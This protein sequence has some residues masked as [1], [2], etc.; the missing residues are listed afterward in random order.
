M[1][2]LFWF[3]VLTM[4]VTSLSACLAPRGD[5]PEQ[6]RAAILSMHD[7]TLARLYQQRPTARDVIDKAAGYAVF[8]NVN[9]LYL[10][11]GG[12]GG[13]GDPKKRP[14]AKV[15]EEVLNGVI[16]VTAAREIAYKHVR[17][18]EW[19]GAFFRSDIGYRAVRR[20]LAPK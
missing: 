20:E 14:A 17:R 2:K 19:E 16:S 5:T 18:I 11:V 6:K 13:Y 10:I 15:A 1:K 8:S 12:G 4:I 3:V 7:D 9:A